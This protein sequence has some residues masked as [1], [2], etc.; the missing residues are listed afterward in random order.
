MKPA[1]DCV[2]AAEINAGVALC[3]YCNK[4]FN[5]RSTGGKAQ[6]FCK[7]EHCDEYYRS[8][9]R[10]VIQLIEQSLIVFRDGR[11]RLDIDTV[12]AKFKTYESSA[13]ENSFADENSPSGSSKNV[14]TS[15]SFG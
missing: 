11:W 14:S 13:L 8:L 7:R 15:N 3:L 1:R 4:P 2:G 5:R 12:N 9:K 6:I 10:V